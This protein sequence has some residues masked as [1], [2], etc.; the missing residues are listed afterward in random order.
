MI[1]FLEKLQAMKN[2]GQIS[3]EMKII[4]GE[5]YHSYQDALATNQHDA[6]SQ[7]P[8][9]LEY[10][11]IVGKQVE[12]PYRFDLYHEKITSPF[13]FYR[14]GLDFLYPLVK[15]EQSSIQGEDKVL[16]IESHLKLGDNVVL[17]ANHQTELDPQAIS[18]L[19]EKTH[20]N[21]A[22]NMIFV[23]GHRVIT[24][25]LAIP[26]SLGRNLLCIFS[27]NYIKH[28]P[29]QRRAKLHHN[30]KTMKRMRELLTEGGQCIYVAPSGGRDRPDDEGIVQVGYF[31]P[32]SI[33][34]F[35]FLSNRT[36]VPTHFYPLAL[37]TFNLLPPPNDIHIKLGEKR[38]TKSSPIHLSFGKELKMT[39][40][41]P[42]ENRNKKELKSLRATLIWEKVKKLYQQLP[43]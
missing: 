15:L 5:F 20:P 43:I 7:D 8:L 14:F 35:W 29:E 36:S 23:A 39:Q 34:M 6:T 33:E 37:S 31:D 38:V 17:F 16:E 10:L 11:Q 27:K 9:L 18:L 28:P 42:P 21:L 24:D 41:P 40:L 22:Q 25:P 26:F 19:L 13:D 12:K 4:I 3:E 32:Q 2:S 30:Q 1:S